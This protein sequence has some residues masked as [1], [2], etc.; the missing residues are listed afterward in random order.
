MR[1]LELMERLSVGPSSTYCPIE[2]AIHVGRYAPALPFCRGRRVLDI[3]C[4]EGYGAWLL[5]RAGALSVQGFDAS[6]DAIDA[7]KRNFQAPNL[8]FHVCD[9]ADLE[10][11]LDGEAF[12]LITCIETV[13]HLAEP[14]A[15]LRQLRR[16][17]APD[18]LILVTCPNDHWYYHG[19]EG[20]PYHLRKYTFSEFQEMTTAEL[21]EDVRW[22]LGTAAQGF[23]AVPVSNLETDSAP[24]R[25]VDVHSL[26]STVLCYPD[27]HDQLDPTT[28]SYFIGLWHARL[29]EFGGGALFPTSMN[30][31]ALR[32]QAPAL[33][34]QLMANDAK[35]RQDQLCANREIASLRE[36]QTADQ[37]KWL[38][39]QVCSSHEIASLREQVA[40]CEAQR[41]HDQ[42]TTDDELTR[43][44]TLVTGLQTGRIELEQNIRAYRVQAASLRRENDI[45]AESV[46][47]FRNEALSAASHQASELA[48]AADLHASEL[49][50]A[51]DLHASEIAEAHAA[52]T[53]AR[54]DVAALEAVIARWYAYKR[55]AVGLIPTVLRPSLRYVYRRIL[56]RARSM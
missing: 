49:A 33:R 45:L 42:K 56:A 22:F 16:L 20:N 27:E 34:D 26:A 3:A 28:C 54:S 14:R 18:C 6:A 37:A 31:Y 4:G 36:Q 1:E 48:R 32:E 25:Y 50:R 47:R 30:A 44:Q 53:R 19:D 43:L 29:A 9:A 41:Q 35:W 8:A 7:A 15:F 21:G 23:V 2:G 46:S 11:R 17:A 40:S 12:D 55:R 38:R 39:D 10:A 24:S 52:L 5:S 13:E 51:A